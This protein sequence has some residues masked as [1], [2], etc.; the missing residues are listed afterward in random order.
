MYLIVAAGGHY[1]LENPQGS[2]I[3]LHDRYIQL[4]R[5]LLSLGVT[6]PCQHSAARV[7][8]LCLCLS[9]FLT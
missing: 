2:L 9:D 3:T 7:S 1:V 6:V 4:L 8:F 5:R